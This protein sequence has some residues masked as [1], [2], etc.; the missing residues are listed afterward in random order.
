MALRSAFGSLAQC[1][2]EQGVLDSAGLA[3]RIQES[4]SL[5]ADPGLRAA[6]EQIA[7]AVTLECGAR[8]ARL[9]ESDLPERPMRP[10]LRL[11][12]EE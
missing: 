10:A 6:L 1:L 4:A 3:E 11:V 12:G 5:Q 2:Q 8:P 9:I 7:E